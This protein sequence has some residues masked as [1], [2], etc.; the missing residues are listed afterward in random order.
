MI[1]GDGAIFDLE[2]IAQ[3]EQGGHKAASLLSEGI[4]KHLPNHSGYQLWVYVF[5][6]KRG[7]SETFHRVSEHQ[8]RLKL[9]DFMIGFNQSTER[10]IMV[11]VGSAKEAADSKIKGLLHPSL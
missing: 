11:D 7:L 2:L 3:G 10:F 1:D 8:V 6:N 5:L 9:D 4:F